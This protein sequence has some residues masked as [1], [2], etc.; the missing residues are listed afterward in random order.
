MTSAIGGYSQPSIKIDYG[1]GGSSSGG[2]SSGGGTSTSSSS[3]KPGVLKTE[4]TYDFR[5]IPTAY[6][7]DSG[8]NYIGT[9]RGLVRKKYATGGLASETGPAWLDGTLSE[10]EYVL[11]AK[12]TDAFLRLADVLPSMMQGGS[13]NT[14][15]TFG[16]INLNLV[17]NVDQIASDYDVDRIADR[18]KDIVYN[19]GQYRNVNTLN[20]MR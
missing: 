14:S 9:A 20:F 7:P 17:M 15:T 16:G 18:V 4:T 5:G 12:Q 3:P 1:T 11:N 6:S 13:N 10:P 2:G 8:S 19:A